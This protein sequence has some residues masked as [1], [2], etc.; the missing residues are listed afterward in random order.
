[1][2]LVLYGSPGLG[3]WFPKFRV[4]AYLSRS[5]FRFLSISLSL[6][7]SPF[8]LSIRSPSHCPSVLRI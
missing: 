5:L 1:M 2:Q 7:L 4:N 8:P 6:S 3:L